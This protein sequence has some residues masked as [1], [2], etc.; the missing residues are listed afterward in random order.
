MATNTI[1]LIIVAAVA[2]LVLVGILVAVMRVTRTQ[3]GDDA[4]RNIRER[5]DKRALQLRRQEA[6]ADEAAATA[7]AALVEAD[8]KTARADTLQHQ[9]TAFRSQ[10]V[11]TRDQLNELRVRRIAG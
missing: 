2:A 10:A 7:H 11:T 5:A 8:I 6:I 9:A 3:Q 4:V 1:V